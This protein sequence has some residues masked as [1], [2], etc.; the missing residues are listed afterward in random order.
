M[1]KNFTI[2]DLQY[3]QITDNTV[4][5]ASCKNK[6]L[7]SIAISNQ[8]TVKGFLGFNPAMNHHMRKK[9]KFEAEF[10]F[11]TISPPLGIARN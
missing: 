6:N 11:T 9:I 3:E 10:H 8:I 4:R 7:T 5:V 1:R 2:D